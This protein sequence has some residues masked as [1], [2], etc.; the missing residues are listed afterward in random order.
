MEDTTPTASK[1][2]RRHAT[3]EGPF[4]WQAKAALRRIRETF[5]SLT[6]LDQAI[7]VYVTLT[8]FASDAQAETFTRR[9]REIAERSGVSLRRVQD[10]LKL[11]KSAELVDWHQNQGASG[12]QELSPS[13]YTL[14][15]VCTTPVQTEHDLVQNAKNGNCTVVQESLEQSLE[16]SQKKRVRK[17]RKTPRTPEAI[18]AE[19]KADAAYS[20]I[21]VQTEYSK[22]VRWYTLKG[23]KPTERRFLGWLNKIEKPLTGSTTKPRPNG[24]F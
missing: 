18:I 12:K 9:R 4:T 14:C 22:M 20:W 7:A 24:L 23:L 5:D 13:T 19:L 3:K 15:S 11:L 21:D 8:E 10:I 6:F 16:Q 1:S 2:S 17:T